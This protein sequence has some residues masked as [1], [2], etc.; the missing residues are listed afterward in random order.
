MYKKLQV[1]DVERSFTLH[2]SL[3]VP[4]NIRREISK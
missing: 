3:A 2:N 1:N 4:R